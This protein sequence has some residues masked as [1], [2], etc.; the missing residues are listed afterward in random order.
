MLLLDEP[1][2]DLDVDTLRALEDALL[3]FAGCAVVISHDRW[4][5]DRIAT[6]MLALRGRQPRSSGSRATT[7][8]YE[9]DRRRRLGAR[10]DQPHRI[11]AHRPLTRGSP[12]G[13]AGAA[14]G[15]AL[16][17]DDPAR[18]GGRAVLSTRRAS[19][20]GCVER[21]PA[22]RTSTG[23]YEVIVVESSGDGTAER[24]PARFPGVRVIAPPSSH[25]ARR[26]PEHRRRR[27]GRPSIAITNHDCPLPPRVAPAV[28]LARHAAG[29]YAAVG[30]AVANG[31]PESAVG[32][33]AFWSEFN[34][35]TVGRPP[36]IVAGVPQCNVCF[37]RK[38]ARRRDA[39]SDR[40]ASA[41]RS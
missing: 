22:P 20:T 17:R 9:A 25:V 36:G 31:T 21:S 11:C 3:D 6:H 12:A 10:R 4:F 24:L 13:S 19:S 32:T 14:P 28:S 33:A 2:N 39:V 5:L 37:R 26:G 1:T 35:F 34:E 7:Q 15:L 30:G 23:P 16:I 38:R 18:L 41:P 8:D 40:R 29:D 27:G